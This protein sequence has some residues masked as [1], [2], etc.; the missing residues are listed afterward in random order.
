MSNKKLWRVGQEEIDYVTAAINGG[1][2]GEFNKT[3]ELDFAKK[4]GVEFAIS[5]NSGNSALH[6]ALFACG[7]G[8]G[9]EVIVPPLTFASPTFAA[10]SLGA[11]PVFADIDPDTFNIDP[12]EIEKKITK[13]TKA[14]I[15]VSLYG[16]PS[17]IAPIM[18]IA[19]KYN[20]KVVEDN[21]ECMLG[22]YQGKIT[23]T[24]A[25]MSIFSF[26]RSKHMTTGSGGMIITNNE[27]MASRAR[28]FSILGY[29][30]LSARQDA[31]KADLD[32][33]QS[34][35]FK[36]H[37]MM[38]FNYRLP[39]VC[40]AMAIAQLKKL[41][42]LV[43]MRKEIAKLYEKSV[44]GCSWLTPQK[45]PEG[46]VNSYWTYVVKLDTKKFSWN[47]FRKTFLALGGERFYGAWSIN[48][49]EPFL[50]GKEFKEH[51]IKYQKGLCPIA[52]ELQPRLI[53]LKTNF[54]DLEY[55]KKQADILQKTIDTLNR[56]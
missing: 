40:A 27:D 5:V 13:K 7:V 50:E 16:L 53:Q 47:N 56:G 15:P 46:F 24:Q 33:A 54:G 43:N 9:D 30:T 25:D 35:D 32:K 45:T 8:V 10:L 6:C 4:F 29:S 12:K 55:A 23:G 31:F 44:Q 52:E 19:K 36:R 21:A 42:M 34:P 20:L 49:L 3:L 14:I 51:N 17:D 11:V 39:A 41:D 38:G 2:T 48:Y 37:E 1:L 28:K 22:T 18:A 26:E